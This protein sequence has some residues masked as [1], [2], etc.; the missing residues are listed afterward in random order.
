MFGIFGMFH[1]LI[2]NQDCLQ[3]PVLFPVRLFPLIFPQHLD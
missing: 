3:L 1:A 2:K